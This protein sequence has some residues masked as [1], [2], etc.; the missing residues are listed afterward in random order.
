MAAVHC[1]IVG[2]GLD[3]RKDKTL[4]EYD[5]IRGAPHALPA[6]HINPYLVDAPDVLAVGQAR[7]ICKVSAIVN[8]SIPADAGHLLLNPAERE[9]LVAEEPQAARF[10][11]PYVGAED[12]IHGLERY[13][14]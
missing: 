13:C 1:V 10:L 8:G 12:F 5:D 11:R 9:A 14:L 2:F 6:A 4:Y 7:P 3:D